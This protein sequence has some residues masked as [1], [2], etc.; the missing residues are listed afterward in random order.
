MDLQVLLREA[1]VPPREG[2]G[3]HRGEEIGRAAEEGIP[4]R[5]VCRRRP[6]AVQHRQPQ[7]DIG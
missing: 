2:R 5:G 7:R 3:P 4:V 1:R 6:L